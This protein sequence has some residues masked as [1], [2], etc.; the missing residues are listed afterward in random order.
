MKNIICL[1]ALISAASLIAQETPSPEDV[2]RI[3]AAVEAATGWTVDELTGGLEMLNHVWREDMKTASGR[4]RWNGDVVS[5][6]IDTNAL[7]K[8]T[9]YTNGYIHVER[10]KTVAA[11]GLQD[12]LTAAER[13]AR[14]EAAAKARAEAE[15]K[16]KA[17]RIAAL[18]TNRVAETAALMKRNKWPEELARLYLL[19]ELN[20]LKGTNTVTITV[21]PGQ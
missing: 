4:K 11:M 3:V 18:E 8:T 9:T 15:A 12:R 1:T 14:A 21:M 19:N 7:T 20:K 17:D 10:F 6:N 13:K 5:V 16:R 2:A